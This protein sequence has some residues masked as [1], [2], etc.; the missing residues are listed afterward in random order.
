M[1][2]SIDVDNLSDRASIESSKQQQMAKE[3]VTAG[4]K[5]PRKPNVSPDKY[6]NRLEGEEVQKKRIHSGVT[7]LIVKPSK[8]QIKEKE[9]RRVEADSMARDTD[10]DLSQIG[11]T[12][13]LK[14]D[15]K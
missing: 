5:C 7:E 8:A 10:G 15:N 1:D 11:T 4:T 2:N 6:M 13:N 3:P 14:R 12:I 9:R